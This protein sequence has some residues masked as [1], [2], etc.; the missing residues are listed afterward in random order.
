M[1]ERHLNRKQYFKEQALTTERYVI[2]YISAVQE[3]TSA[4][5]VLEIGCGEG[6]NMLPF[7]Q[8]GCDV[9]GVDLNGGK[10][11]MAEEYIREAVPNGSFKLINDDIYNWDLKADEKFDLIILRDVIEHIHDQ[12]RFMAFFKEL[13]KPNGKVF[14]GF[15]PWCMP[16]GGHQQICK[17]KWT[18]KVPFY[19]LLPMSLYKAILRGAGES[20]RIVDSLV[21]IKETGISTDRFERI[22]RKNG[23]QID[24]K[25]RYFINPNYE[26]KFG[27][28]PRKLNP[29]IGLF[30]FVRDFFTTCYYGVISIK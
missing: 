27:L 10:L 2:P 3:I 12:N 23:Y 5:R 26:I 18:S 9:T 4:T 6:G 29:V 24:R 16:F 17:K 13:I 7:V 30:P 11:K 28:K 25:T 8:M 1:Q 19:H 20:D 15:P 14:F 21:E 22:V